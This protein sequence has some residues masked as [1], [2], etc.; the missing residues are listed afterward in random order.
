M[1]LLDLAAQLVDKSGSVADLKLSS[2][3]FSLNGALFVR[4]WARQLLGEDLFLLVASAGV[5][6]VAHRK[7][8]RQTIKFRKIRK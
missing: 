3:D 1:Q 7:Y 6:L 5:E 4:L 8:L 2:A